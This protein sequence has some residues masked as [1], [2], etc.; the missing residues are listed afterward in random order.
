MK[1]NIVFN[2]LNPTLCFAAEELSSYL[3]KIDSKVSINH[4]LSSNTTFTIYLNSNAVLKEDDQYH[5]LITSTLINLSGNNSRSILLGVYKLLYLI[6]CRFLQ[7][8]KKYEYI[9]HI[10]LSTFF[11]DYSLDKTYTPSFKHRGVCIE[12][13]N[14][15]ENVLDF[16]DWLPKL[17]Y[18][19]FFVQFKLPYTFFE[20]WYNHTFNPLLDNQPLTIEDVKIFDNLIREALEKRNLIYHKVGHGWTCE[21]LG[22][23]DLGWQ[24]VGQTLSE[25]KTDWLASVGGKRELWKG[26]PTNTNLCYAHPEAQQAFI[27]NIVNYA[28]INPSIDYLHVWLADEHNNICECSKCRDTLLS[29]QYIHILNILDQELSKLNLPTKIVFLIYQELLWPPIDNSLINADRFTLMFAPISRTFEKSYEDCTITDTI[30]NYVRNHIQL[31]S[32]LE[33]NLSFLKKWQEKWTGDSFVYD[34]PLGRAHYGDPGYINI[35][36]IINQDIKTLKSLGLH[37]YISCQELRVSFPHSLP[38]YI[39]GLTLFDSEADFDT[40]TQD[41]FAHMYHD[42][43]SLCQSYFQNISNLF[44]C[45]YFNGIGPRRNPEQAHKYLEAV[46]IAE[47]FLKNLS[48]LKD[49]SNYFIKKLYFHTKYVKLLGKALYYL[50]LNESTIA[51]TYYEEFT[52]LIQ[53]HESDFQ[54]AF[55]VYRIIE[56]STKYTGFSLPNYY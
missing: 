45:D 23:N 44:S 43:A 49:N 56:V 22:M 20:R 37:G 4:N 18:N 52:R 32:S 13:A 8:G 51:Q 16:I 36:R 28:K 39:M 31:P 10:D 55:D 24:K 17:G 41:Y 29:D 54:E 1:I 15:I 25:E 40:L 50:A 33:E 35:S 7:P 14:S 27:E 46:H 6:G 38:N 12:G 47:D 9:P 21:A 34:Y 42:K 2:S 53:S 48:L 5:L 11:K 19:T 26:I 3:K 30:P